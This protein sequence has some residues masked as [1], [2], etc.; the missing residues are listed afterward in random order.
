MIDGVR[1][2]SCSQDSALRRFQMPKRTT[3][4]RDLFI[5]CIFL[6]LVRF[7]ATCRGKFN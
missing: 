7:F 3:D 6:D 5:Y 1:F 2:S 4:L